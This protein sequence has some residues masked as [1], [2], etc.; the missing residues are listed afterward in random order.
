MNGIFEEKEKKNKVMMLFG[1]LK[2]V[3]GT[4]DKCI[5]MLIVWMFFLPNLKN[6]TSV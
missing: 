2:K 5:K 4:I 6:A 3:L 1:T